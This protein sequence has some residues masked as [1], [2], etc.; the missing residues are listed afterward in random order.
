VK[1]FCDKLKAVARIL[2]WGYKIRGEARRA[3]SG[4]GVLGEGAARPL[5]TS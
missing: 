3:E 4:R 2:A 5:P 1:Q